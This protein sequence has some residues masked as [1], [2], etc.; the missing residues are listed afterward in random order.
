M[1]GFFGNFGRILVEK[2]SWYKLLT[3][4]ALS[5][6]LLITRPM[7]AS[8]AVAQVN[9]PAIIL[10][11][12]ISLLII[13]Y[14]TNMLSACMNSHKKVLPDIDFAGMLGYT[15]RI[16]PFALLWVVYRIFFYGILTVVYIS[17]IYNLIRVK[18]ILAIVLII[19]II[20]TYIYESSLLAVF[21]IHTKSFSFNRILNPF[22]PLII[23]PRI[24]GKVIIA[25]LSQ[26]IVYAL[27]FSIAYGFVLL[28]GMSALV[29]GTSD[30]TSILGLSTPLLI[31]GVLILVGLFYINNAASYAYLNTIA[32]IVKTN[33]CDSEYLD[34]DYD[35]V[36]DEEKESDEDD[37]E[38][39]G[40]RRN[41]DD[42]LDY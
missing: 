5:I 16:I 25:S 13:G 3:M 42:E 14:V 37:D 26:G 23:A 29:N 34:D 21:A 1:A 2:G 22:L 19:G 41:S 24:I 15:F 30:L 36:S 10:Y 35:I 7:I 32:D 31:G 40:Y 18:W 39:A 9:I 6:I 11:L 27:T 17:A 20:L 4:A 33:L 28:F 8:I 12:L 38:F